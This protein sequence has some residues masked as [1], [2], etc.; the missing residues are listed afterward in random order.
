[1]GDYARIVD[2]N[3]KRTDNGAI[4]ALELDR[5]QNLKRLANAYSPITVWISIA[6]IMVNPK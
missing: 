2:L 6:V 1:M 3:V 5:P 4:N